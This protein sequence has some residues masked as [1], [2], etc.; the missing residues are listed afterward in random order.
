L[1]YSPE[2]LKRLLDGINT[3]RSLDSRGPTQI[4]ANRPIVIR[5]P[6]DSAPIRIPVQDTTAPLRQLNQNIGPD[7]YANQALRQAREQRS[8]SHAVGMG[9]PITPDSQFDDKDRM[10]ERSATARQVNIL[11]LIVYA[12]FSHFIT[13]LFVEAALNTQLRLVLTQTITMNGT[14]GQ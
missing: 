4:S 3:G 8:A 11:I 13:V 1:D 2:T 5:K 6:Y 12:K 9:S 7:D 10:F 14:K